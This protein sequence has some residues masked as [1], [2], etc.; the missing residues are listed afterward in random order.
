MVDGSGLT[1]V[2]KDSNKNKIEN[3]VSKTNQNPTESEKT[4]EKK[5]S[6]RSKE[7]TGKTA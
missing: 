6:E 4:D 1:E 3:K 7:A 5:L 2:M